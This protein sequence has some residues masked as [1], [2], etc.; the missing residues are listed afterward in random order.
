MLDAIELDDVNADGVQVS[1]PTPS[2][3]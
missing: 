3:T 2:P 1:P